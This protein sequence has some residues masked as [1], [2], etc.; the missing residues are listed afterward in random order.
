MAN[1]KQ[2]MKRVLTNNKKNLLNS[3]FVSSLKTA[4]KAFEAS[5]AAGN[6]EEATANYALLSKKLDKSVSKGIHHKNYVAR[7]KSRAAKALNRL[8]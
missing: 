3:S 7:E 2:Q 8:N 6:K 5:V 1:T 4:M